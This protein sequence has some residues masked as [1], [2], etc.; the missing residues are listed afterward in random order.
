MSTSRN[1]LY[2]CLPC[3]YPNH[4]KHTVCSS[5]NLSEVFHSLNFDPVLLPNTLC[6]CYQRW[7]ILLLPLHIILLPQ[8]ITKNNNKSRFYI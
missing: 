2:S 5:H 8:S 1:V 7:H 4:Q 3:I 6:V